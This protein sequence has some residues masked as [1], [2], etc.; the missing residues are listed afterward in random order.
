MK[1]ELK[2]TYNIAVYNSR[3][4]QHSCLMK[5]YRNGNMCHDFKHHKIFNRLSKERAY[6]FECLNKRRDLVK[7]MQDRAEHLLPFPCKFVKG[8]KILLLLVQ[9]NWINYA[10]CKACS[11]SAWKISKLPH[12]DIIIVITCFN[13]QICTTLKKSRTSCDWCIRAIVAAKMQ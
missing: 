6:I 5:S 11:I 13:M 7:T 10:N 8:I 4:A 2:A 1:A 9:S 12:L 3:H